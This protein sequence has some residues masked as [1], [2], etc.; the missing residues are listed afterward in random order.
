MK[1]RMLVGAAGIAGALIAIG[2]FSVD[3][4]DKAD[5]LDHTD[6]APQ[7]AGGFPDVYVWNVEGSF[8]VNAGGIRAY[9]VG[10][11]S[12]NEGTANLNWFS[13]NN[14]HPVI[15][16]NMFM[17][18]EVDGNMRFQQLGQGW[19]KHGFCALDQTE[20][21]PCS[22][23]TGCPSL[24]VGCSD[25]YTASRNA[26][27]APAGPKYQ[28]NATT[29]VFPYP[30]DN[31]SWSGNTARRLRVPS[32]DVQNSSTTGAQYFIEAQ[33]VHYQDCP[34]PANGN[35]VGTLEEHLAAARDNVTYGRMNMSNSG[36]FN[37][38]STN[39]QKE[40]A[41]MEWAALEGVKLS[42]IGLVGEGHY[43]VLSAVYGPD[44]DG[45]YEYE[46]YVH[47]LDSHRSVSGISIPVDDATT[48]AFRPD[49]PA[50]PSAWSLYNM[51]HVKY[52]N[53]DGEAGDFSSAPW[54]KAHD[55]GSVSW[56]TSSFSTDNNANAIRWGTGYNFRFY[57]NSPPKTGA[58]ELTHYR[59][60]G[61]PSFMAPD[62]WVPSEQPCAADFDFDG[63][64]GFSDIVTI[65]TE[66]GPCD[67]CY[68]DLDG[69]ND[70][71]FTDLVIVL[72]SWGPC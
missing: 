47:N 41:L 35:Q 26:S 31:P 62:V 23:G 43:F 13:F 58:I 10:T 9:S 17:L 5:G 28:V 42:E 1:T 2:Q 45:I 54:A 70:V 39:V 60:D 63:M 65:L 33:Y 21:G 18:A 24:A 36:Q 50:V 32:A 38:P 30:P 8:N 67:C 71:G 52:Y 37:G 29:G 64:V 20:C 19:L 3:A 16:Q 57:A 22:N 46:Y 34:A 48:V 53:G 40:P 66:W 51:R 68:A 27:Q 6:H 61:D 49:P 11:T 44:Q 7:E 12:C 55:C 69:N 72:S 25:P 14:Q 59:G 15:G 56:N 4:A